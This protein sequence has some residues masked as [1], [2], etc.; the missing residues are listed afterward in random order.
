[1]FYDQ[2]GLISAHGL[3]VGCGGGLYCPNDS[4]L[5]EQ[6]AA[7][8]IR[9]LGDSNPYTPAA[10]RFTDVPPSN[11]FYKFI[12]QMYVRQITVGCGGTNYCP[13]QPVLREQMA[14]FI[15]RSLGQLNPPTPAS[16]RFN[17]VPPSSAFY[18]YV[19]RMA[20]LNITAGCSVSSPL[21]CPSDPVSRAQMAAFLVRAFNL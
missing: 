7:F 4:V 21:F 2:I 11:A 10:Q 5:R 17:D 8:I 12:E 9:A 15:I 6:M 14:A 3:T 18:N 1:M 20:V 19:D 16:Q 13:S